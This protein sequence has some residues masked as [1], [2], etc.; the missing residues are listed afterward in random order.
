MFCTSALYIKHKSVLVNWN[1]TSFVLNMNVC[2]LTGNN[3]HL[4]RKMFLFLKP[5][6]FYVQSFSCSVSRM[7]FILKNYEAGSHIWQHSAIISTFHEWTITDNRKWS[8]HEKLLDLISNINHS[9]TL[10]KLTIKF[11][12]CKSIFLQEKHKMY[13]RYKNG[14][15]K[16]FYVCEKSF[17]NKHSS[18]N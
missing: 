5:M 13:I 6:C 11:V 9:N 8:M 7:V 10:L 12:N 18:Q 15:I 2:K 4:F 14:K 16:Y 3:L 17:K 1:R